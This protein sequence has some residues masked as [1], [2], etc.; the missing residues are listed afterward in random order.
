[1]L[2]TPKGETSFLR[3]DEVLSMMVITNDDNYDDG[4]YS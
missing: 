3:G 2:V 4:Y 1:M